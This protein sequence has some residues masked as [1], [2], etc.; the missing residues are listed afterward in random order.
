[1]EKKFGS[2]IAFL[3]PNSDEPERM[4]CD[5]ECVEDGATA[6]LARADGEGT[7]DC[8]RS[9]GIDERPITD[10]EGKDLIQVAAWAEENGY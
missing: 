8:W 3:G 1:M 5:I 7:V 2:L 6:S 10:K 9:Y 4:D